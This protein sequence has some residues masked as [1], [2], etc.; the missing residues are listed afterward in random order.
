MSAPAFRA[1]ATRYKGY[2]FRSRLEARW[3][4]FFDHLGIRWD[5]E[6]EGFELGNGLRYLPDFWLPDWDIW[7]EIKPGPPDEVA[8]TKAMRL[9]IAQRKP[10]ILATGMPGA[11]CIAFIPRAESVGDV[12]EHDAWLPWSEAGTGYV[13]APAPE[14]H[15]PGCSFYPMVTLGT[16]LYGA[17]ENALLAARGAQFEFGVKGGAL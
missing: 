2:K 16:E 9:V 7:L 10:L 12:S 17:A 14:M 4:V 15:G 13:A 3:A 5:Y 11:P 6:S 1:I 8:R